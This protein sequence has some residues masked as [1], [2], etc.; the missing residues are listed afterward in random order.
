MR[1]EV[2]EHVLAGEV[3]RWCRIH[4]ARAADIL[5]GNAISLMILYA[6]ILVIFK[7]LSTKLNWEQ[8]RAVHSPSLL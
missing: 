2:G 1:S 4:G 8:I 7:E 3:F 5:R 6:L